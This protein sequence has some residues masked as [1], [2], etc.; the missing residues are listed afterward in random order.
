MFPPPFFPLPFFF[1]NALISIQQQF[2]KTNFTAKLLKSEWKSK[3]ER[4]FFEGG[5]GERAGRPPVKCDGWEEKDSSWPLQIV[6]LRS[7]PAPTPILPTQQQTPLKPTI[8]SVE[9]K[10][11]IGSN[12]ERLRSTKWRQTALKLRVVFMRNKRSPSLAVIRAVAGMF[13]HQCLWVEGLFTWRTGQIKMKVL[14]FFPGQRTKIPH[15]AF[16]THVFDFLLTCLF[17]TIS[18]VF[19]CAREAAEWLLATAP[20]RSFLFNHFFFFTLLLLLFFI[21]CCMQHNQKQPL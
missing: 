13:S 10:F 5:W 7:T 12:S 11:S 9:A 20:L 18:D 2:G 4:I 17:I 19:T 1:K 8:S 6:S 21:Q 16:L 14:F 3:K 15:L